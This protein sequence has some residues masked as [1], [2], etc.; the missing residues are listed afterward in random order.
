M[1][2]E[3]I[4]NYC[5]NYYIPTG[6]CQKYCAY[7]RHIVTL[8]KARFNDKKRRGFKG[9]TPLKGINSPFYKDGI[10]VYSLK[11]KTEGA[12]CCR[13]GNN[14]NL[15]VHHKDS[16]R[17]NNVD[18]NLVVLCKSCHQKLHHAYKISVFNLEGIFIAEFLGYSEVIDFIV[19][20]T[21]FRP[22][23]DRHL[24]YAIKN[25]KSAYG[26]YFKQNISKGIV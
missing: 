21:D 18:E 22:K 25:N 26:Y 23:T 19:K 24:R 9:R 20:N 4:C 6:N 1:L 13:C 12:F 8:A 11:A 10:G 3:K 14:K 7:C 5:G 2:K 15:I 16:N 17:H